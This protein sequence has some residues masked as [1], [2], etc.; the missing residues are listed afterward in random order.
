MVAAPDCVVGLVTRR[1]GEQG[2]RSMVVM[3]VGYSACAEPPPFRS[4]R[5]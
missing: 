5:F 4:A 1:E 3:D 2:M